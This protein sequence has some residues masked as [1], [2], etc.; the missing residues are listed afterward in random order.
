MRTKIHTLV[1]TL[2]IACLSLLLALPAQAREDKFVPAIGEVVTNFIGSERAVVTAE[3][4]LNL[5]SL[6]GKLLPGF[7]VFVDNQTFVSS[8]VFANITGDDVNEIIVVGRNGDTYSLFA[9]NGAGAQISSIQLGTG[10]IYYD[11]VATI[12][13]GLAFED[14]VVAGINGKVMRYRLANNS[15]TETAVADTGIATGLAMNSDKNVLI[16]NFPT[17]NGIRVYSWHGN[18]LTLDINVPLAHSII[19]PVKDAGNGVWYGINNA[20]ALVGF[21]PITG[22]VA[23]GFPVNSAV[24]PISGPEITDYDDSS[25]GNELIVPLANGKMLIVTDHGNVLAQTKKKQSLVES[26]TI[27]KHDNSKDVLL[28]RKDDG[29]KVISRLKDYTFSLLTRLGMTISEGVPS[30]DLKFADDLIASGANFDA[31]TYSTN[32]QFNFKV[33]IENAGN[34]DLLLNGPTPIELVGDGA[35]HCQIPAQPETTVAG[36]SSK[37]VGIVCQYDAEGDQTIE[38]H[39]QNNI[40]DK[41]PYVVFGKVKITTNKVQDGLMEAEGLDKWIKYGTPTTLEKSTAVFKNGS[42][43]MH[44][45]APSGFQ[46]RFVAVEA[47]KIYRFSFYY[48][49]KNSQLKAYLGNNNSNGDFEG[50]MAILINADQWNSYAREFQVPANFVGDWRVIFVTMGEAYVDDVKIEEIAGFSM[51]QDGDMEN[52]TTDRWKK[53]GTP[54]IMEKSAI[55]FKNGKR[56]MRINTAG[57]GG[58][59]QQTFIPVKAGKSY[60]LSFYARLT[61]GK[62]R[63]SLGNNDSNS[64]FENKPIIIT[65]IGDFN[66]YVREFKVPDNFTG[67]W[68]LVF[69]LAN[70]EAYVDDIEISPLD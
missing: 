67:D 44:V 26:S 57:T 25:P 53:Y 48:N 56:S 23:D 10:E 37:E 64:D 7:P 9:F 36:N 55:I 11:P 27:A 21:N 45:V 20:G 19:Y 6:R 43:S 51:I 34:G 50:R 62:Y 60:R 14:I 16:F 5:Y 15:F 68:R 54:P 38:I 70:G 32:E 41:S 35:L 31:G 12:Q 2:T 8:P 29:I 3:G 33:Q 58:G 28:G 24:M 4:G 46:Q 30:I 65:A 59:F 61:S 47:G 39:V 40:P 66:Q 49:S 63:I 42:R 22:N 1:A 13:P 69:S 17:Q 52:P 18:N